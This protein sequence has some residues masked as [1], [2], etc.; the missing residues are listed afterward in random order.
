[1]S[2]IRFELSKL[3]SNR[4]LPHSSPRSA[5]CASFNLLSLHQDRLQF[6]LSIIGRDNLG[7][8]Y[9][10]V[11]KLDASVIACQKFSSQIVSTVSVFG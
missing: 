5:Y 8:I 1:V 11:V 10:S 6:I 9:G 4:Q 7:K 3:Q 2:G